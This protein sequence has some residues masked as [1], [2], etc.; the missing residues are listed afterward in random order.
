MK[1]KNQ[2]FDYYNVTLTFYF[3]R[4]ADVITI[5]QTYRYWLAYSSSVGSSSWLSF[6][7]I[8]YRWAD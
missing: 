2:Y 3:I 4:L 1:R 6:M 7:T 8:C 5:I